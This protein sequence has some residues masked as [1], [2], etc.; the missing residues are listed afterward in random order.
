[1]RVQLAG[2]TAPAGGIKTIRLTHAVYKDTDFDLFFA[3][4]TR[5]LNSIII[6]QGAGV[7]YEYKVALDNAGKV[8]ILGK[9]SPYQVNT[10]PITSWVKNGVVADNSA[11]RR[12]FSSSATSTTST[13]VNMGLEQ[14]FCNGGGVFSCR[15]NRLV[16]GTEGE[17]G[18]IM[19]LTKNDPT[20]TTPNFNEGIY[21]HAIAVDTVDGTYSY[22][23][24][25]QIDIT[26]VPI[27][28]VG[29][30]D[31]DN[32]V[33]TIQLTGN[34]YKY[35]IY[36]V[37]NDDT[38]IEL[39][40]VD[41]TLDDKNLLYPFIIFKGG[42]DRCA[43]DSVKY[44]PSPYNVSP[45]NT[46]LSSTVDLPNNFTGEPS[47]RG[48][49]KTVQFVEFVSISLTN[50]LGF[51]N[52]INPQPVVA[53][54]ELNIISPQEFIPTSFTDSFLVE[55]LNLT[56]DSYDGGTSG[57]RNLLAVIPQSYNEKQQIVYQA[58]NL[59]WIDLLNAF[60]IDLREVRMRLVRDDDSPLRIRGISTAVIMIKDENE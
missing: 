42:S 25:G 49:S 56:V 31:N 19:G 28:Y 24:K 14:L 53:V 3:D 17:N 40:S 27:D 21:E 35:I 5:K 41:R 46:T 29:D 22:Y 10:I 13:N 39:F 23:N 43:V 36:N 47:G 2:S 45:Y 60:P 11:K 50:Y 54:A 32:P 48:N 6:S 12:Y 52:Q 51:V 20:T 7:G 1:M 15:I 26:D 18:F 37:N 16:D 9:R 8:S 4:F 38:G 44:T 34:Q 58:S 30:D 59:L 33:L 55:L 57:R